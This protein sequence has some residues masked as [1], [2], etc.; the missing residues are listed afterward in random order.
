VGLFRSAG[1]SKYISAILL[2]HR[3]LSRFCSGTW[4]YCSN[5]LIASLLLL[6]ASL[7]KRQRIKGRPRWIPWPKTD[8]KSWMTEATNNQPL[9]ANAYN[10]FD[11][12]SCCAYQQHLEVDVVIF[13]DDRLEE[14]ISLVG[15]GFPASRRHNSSLPFLIEGKALSPT[16]KTSRS[17]GF[18]VRD[19]S[20]S[21]STSTLWVGHVSW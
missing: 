13:D 4:K 2:Q 15:N 20:D 14:L 12:G 16:K 5:V 21:G 3:L 19:L 7:Q 6:S 10:V 9:G 1:I 11:R 8:L 17:T 18:K